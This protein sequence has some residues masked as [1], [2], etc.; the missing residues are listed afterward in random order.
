MSAF[1]LYFLLSAAVAW[2]NGCADQPGPRELTR[3]VELPQTTRVIALNT[4]TSEQR[5]LDQRLLLLLNCMS[6]RTG[7]NVE[8]TSGF[9]SCAY[10]RFRGVGVRNSAHLRAKA[11]DYKIQGYSSL[12]LA[13]LARACGCRGIGVYCGDF[14]HCD[15]EGSR[16]WNWCGRGR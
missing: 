12:Q 6:Q 11:V 7:K 15:I 14:G 4:P 3:I 8:V 9:R 1:L 13:E 2:S 10:Q 16:Q 5:K